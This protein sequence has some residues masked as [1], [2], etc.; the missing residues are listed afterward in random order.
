MSEV[1]KTSREISN[2]LHVL[3][4]YRHPEQMSLMKKIKIFVG[5][6][7]LL[8]VR[9][10]LCPIGIIPPYLMSFLPMSY[11]SMTH[12]VF[13]KSCKWSARFLLF[14]CGFYKLNVVDKRVQKESSRLIVSN[15]T[16]L[17]DFLIMVAVNDELPTFICRSTISKIPFLSRIAKT[18]NCLYI[19]RESNG[20]SKLIQTRLKLPGPPLAFFPEATTTNGLYIISFKT[21]VFVPGIAVLPITFEYSYKYFSPA[22]ESIDWKLW[23]FR[24]LTEFY[25]SCTVTI[26]PIYYPSDLEKR[27][28]VV[29]AENMQCFIADQLMLPMYATSRSNQLIYFDYLQD[30]ITFNEAY[31]KIYNKEI[32]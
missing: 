28:A 12:T 32:N 7:G 17:F 2:S 13:A 3:P 21:G 10:M 15:H 11:N 8:P 26:Y 25:H 27:D 9:L 5:S 4:F 31:E 23:L 1:E 14:I 18:L 16:S 24:S 19:S 22:F 30:R 20:V 29:Y 6:V